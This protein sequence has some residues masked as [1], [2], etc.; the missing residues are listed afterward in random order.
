PGHLVLEAPGN[1]ANS[2]YPGAVDNLARLGAVRD[3]KGRPFLVT[4]LDTGVDS[5]LSYAN[6][7][8]AN[9]AVIVPVAGG[10]GDREALRVIG[11]FYPDREVVSVPGQTLLFGGGGPHCIS[12]QIPV[13]DPVPA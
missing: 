1:P 10:E 9:R 11:D 2:E 8:L 3:A 4:P 13:G 7:Y 12:Q 5:D 6:F